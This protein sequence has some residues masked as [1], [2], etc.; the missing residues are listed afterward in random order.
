LRLDQP[1]TSLLHQG[2]A[3]SSAS[4]AACF[5]DPRFGLG[6]VG[7]ERST[8]ALRMVYSRRLD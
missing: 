2:R 1:T 3:R 4:S 6:E 8:S 7:L 5:S